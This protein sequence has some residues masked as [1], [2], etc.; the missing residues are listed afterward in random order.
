MVL[1]IWVDSGD[2]KILNIT[3]LPEFF[4]ICVGASPMQFEYVI[5]VSSMLQLR[6]L[7]GVGLGLF[8]LICPCVV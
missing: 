5:D 3:A 1:E 6:A 8:V 7:I 4:L 2:V